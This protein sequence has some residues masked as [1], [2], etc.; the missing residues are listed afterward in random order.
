MSDISVTLVMKDYDH[1]APL[2]AG[3][4]DVDGVNLDLVRD[5]PKA[6]DR[7]LNDE[8]IEVGELS[9]ARHIIR[10][11]NDDR[12]FVGIP[13][14]P[15]RNFRNRSFFVKKDSDISEFS[16]LEG[17]RIG[18]NEWPA[19]GNTWGRALLRERGVNIDSINWCVG[20]IVDPP[21]T[22]RPQGELPEYVRPADSD[23]TLLGM[24][25]DDELDALMC[26][27]SRFRGR[28]GFH[29]DE[30]PVVR[31][32]QDYRNSE[33]EY[34]RRIGLYPIAHLI[35]I[36]R[37][38]FDRHPW[39]AQSLFD[40]LDESKSIWHANRRRLSE[41]TPWMEAEIEEVTELMDEDWRPNGI[42]PNREEIE[43]L[44]EEVHAQGLIHEPLIIDELFE[45]Y[46]ELIS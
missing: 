41:T 26:P 44:C 9:F 46:N 27:I 10:L 6:L 17:K 28:Y 40:A 5:T 37:D 43:T 45:E 20:P 30:S 35:G 33:K 16:Q 19:T 18:T 15:T 32:K 12:S 1:I 31:L 25:H 3:D 42:K 38:V 14:F 29:N 36:R 24:L 21:K 11:A 34:Y 22:V 2:A 8:S 13:I 7:T 39:I 4:V 23:Q